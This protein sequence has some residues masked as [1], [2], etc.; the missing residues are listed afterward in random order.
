MCQSHQK[1]PP[2]RP[3]KKAPSAN[4]RKPIARL[5]SK[6]SRRDFEMEDMVTPVGLAQTTATVERLP[7]SDIAVPRVDTL[8]TEELSQRQ[9]AL[10]AWRPLL[11]ADA[12]TSTVP[13][14]VFI[15]AFLYFADCDL[16][17]APVKCILQAKISQ[18][19]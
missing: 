3:L 5:D 13:D 15:I 1:P 11:I 16:T 6:R 10:D 18:I 19:F 2:P 17:M 14:E 8:S 4:P 7:K 12:N 9:R